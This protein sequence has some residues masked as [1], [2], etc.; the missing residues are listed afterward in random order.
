MFLHHSSPNLENFTRHL[1]WNSNFFLSLSSRK[2]DRDG[3]KLTRG[4]VFGGVR[5]NGRVH[6]SGQRP[7]AFSFIPLE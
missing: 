3:E 5:R 4:K 6:F 7:T 1:R 2:L